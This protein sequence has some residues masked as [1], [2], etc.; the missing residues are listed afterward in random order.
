LLSM[1]YY[2]KAESW[3]GIGGR[4]S[5]RR[6]RFQ[7]LSFHRDQMGSGE[8]LVLSYGNVRNESDLWGTREDPLTSMRVTD[9]D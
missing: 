2:L 4:Y 8:I 7:S 9:T 3:N 1:S 6:I 5:Q